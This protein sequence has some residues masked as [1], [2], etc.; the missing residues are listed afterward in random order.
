MTA[1]KVEVIYITCAHGRIELKKGKKCELC[2]LW[3]EIDGK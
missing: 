3:Q 2:V 1:Q